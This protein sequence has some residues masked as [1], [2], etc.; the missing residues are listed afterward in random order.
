MA[1]RFGYA[2]S[3]A[4][5]QR[6]GTNRVCLICRPQTTHRADMQIVVEPVWDA[7][8]V[9]VVVVMVMVTAVTETIVGVAADRGCS[10]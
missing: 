10:G 4:C 6:A 9:V 3:L 1:F 2:C 5:L 7:G 8:V